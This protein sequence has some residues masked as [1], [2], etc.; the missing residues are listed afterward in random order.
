M[1]CFKFDFLY[2]LLLGGVGELWPLG[3][4]HYGNIQLYSQAAFDT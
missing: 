3:I 1:Y 4:F 2:Y